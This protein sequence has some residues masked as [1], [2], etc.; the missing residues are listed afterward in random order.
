MVYNPKIHRRRSIRLKGY[1]YSQSGMYYITMVAQNWLCLFGH[2]KNGK[3]ILNDAGAM[4][5][6]VWCDIPKYY[7]G[8]D[9]DEYVVMPNHFHGVIIINDA[10]DRAATGNRVNECVGNGPRA[11]P[12]IGAIPNERV[13]PRA[14]P[15]MGAVT[16][17]RPI[18]SVGN[19]PRAI[20]KRGHIPN[21]EDNNRAITVNRPH[22]CEGNGPRAIPDEITPTKL[23]LPDVIGRFKSMVMTNY[24]SGV[25]E[26]GWP[27]FYKKLWH[28]NY[29]D[30]I[31]RNEKDYER[32]VEYIRLNPENWER[33]KNNL[34]NLD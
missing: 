8:F 18:E 28:R 22:E 10:D 23:S 3:M 15:I 29:Y 5:E 1:D 6:S 34:K 26:K 20:P 11:I 27:P 16:G 17:N 25:K 19:G 9:V 32:I 13:G 14:N 7:S 24:S 30:H 33:D 12:K 21:D 4:I 2:V 31:I